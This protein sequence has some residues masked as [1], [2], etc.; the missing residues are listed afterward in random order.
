ME[1]D[2]ENS[3]IRGATGL[4]GP[5]RPKDRFHKLQWPQRLVYLYGDWSAPEDWYFIHD[6]QLEGHGYFV[7][8]DKLS[9]LTLGYLGRN[10]LQPDE[11]TPEE[12]FPVSGRKVFGQNT[13][14]ILNLYGSEARPNT[15]Y[16]LTDDGVMQINT[17][18]RTVK[19]LWAGANAISA[20]MS[21]KPR[22]IAVD[23]TSDKPRSLT[24]ILIRLPDRVLVLGLD[25]KEIESYALPAELPNV[26]LSWLL[27][28][29]SEAV[30]EYHK[31]VEDTKDTEL[32]WLDTTG[33]IAR[34]IHVDLRGR[35]G[36]PGTLESAAVPVAMPVP[37]LVLGFLISVPWAVD[38]RS[39][40]SLSYFAALSK[41]LHDVWP[42][43]VISPLIGIVMAILCFRRQRK[44]GLP[45]TGLWTGLA[46][47]FGWPFYLGYLA[48]RVWPARL[49]CP[50]CG[51]LA[52]RD[53]PACF[54]CGREF[55]EPAM[56]GTEVFA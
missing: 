44:Y 47:V 37:G 19:T 23:E 53:R 21:E 39:W 45:W 35:S 32:L 18:K 14:A 29:G 2:D 25:G 10:G 20:A 33:K 26:G 9:K 30:V 49:P 22:T 17:K 3:A 56:K 41:A 52:P 42:I 13:G 51:K 27:F 38:E 54:A 6:G 1:V 34:Q 24:T 48:H 36:H 40:D 28:P 50:H 11:P 12:Q 5:P 16:L 55:P 15:R 7:G 31:N 43:F 8:Y 4:S 46:L